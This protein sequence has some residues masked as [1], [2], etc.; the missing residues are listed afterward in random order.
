M[1][2]FFGESAP[3]LPATVLMSSVQESKEHMTSHDH[4]TTNGFIGKFILQKAVTPSQSEFL[5]RVSGEVGGSNSKVRN[6]LDQV[7][8][9]TDAAWWREMQ[10]ACRVPRDFFGVR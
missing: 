2:G 1:F 4:T 8:N 3:K 7:R 6:V 9:P 5:A 10:H